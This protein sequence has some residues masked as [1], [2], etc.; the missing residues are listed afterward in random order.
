[1]TA[2]PDKPSIVSPNEAAARFACGCER[3]WDQRSPW[4]DEERARMMCNVHGA[5]RIGLF[6]GIQESTNNE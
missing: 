5:L 2:P 6:L 4:A 1:M 3:R